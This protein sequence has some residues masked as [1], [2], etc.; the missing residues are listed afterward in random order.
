MDAPPNIEGAAAPEVAGVVE[1]AC[2]PLAPP[3][4]VEPP[5]KMP[6]DGAEGVVLEG[7]P[8]RPEPPVAPP[9]PPPNALEPV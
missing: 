5:P 1:L 4:G 6:P 9:A 3:A 7:F 8:K 2:A